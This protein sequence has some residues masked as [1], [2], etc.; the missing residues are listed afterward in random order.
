MDQDV[1][2]LSNEMLIAILDKRVELESANEAE[3][4][5]FL[6]E[7]ISRRLWLEY[8]ADS[9]FDFMTRAHY[10]YPPA[11][12]QRK[13]DAA[14]LMQFFP[15]VKDLLLADEINLT[16]LGMLATGLRQ[17]PVAPET[18]REI[19]QSLRG[20]TVKD[21]QIILNEA[22]GLK[23]KTRSK[24]RIQ[25][26][27]SVRVEATFTKE[28]WAIIERAKELISHSVPSGEITQV[29][30]YCAR[31]TVSK[32]DLSTSVREVK[33][34]QSQSIS[35][36]TRRAVF[37]RDKTCRHR[38]AD[39]RLCESRYQLQVD[40]VISRWR[41]GGNDIENLQLLCGVHNRYKFELESGSTSGSWIRLEHQMPA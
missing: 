3:M 1:R 34:R 2:Q 20:Q 15:E 33:P 16:Q 9:I 22:L 24:V 36:A 17:K 19:L 13:I 38:Q 21:T 4:I 25:R 32:K 29:L 7:V 27:G 14:R 26:D 10:H 39:G 5:D 41:G 23:V 11:V 28:D 31:F 30:A 35:R 8:G 6:R 37:H 12:A 40:H 18:Q